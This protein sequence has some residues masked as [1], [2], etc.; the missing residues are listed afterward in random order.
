L[1][2]EIKYKKYKKYR[3]YRQKFR[4][5]NHNGC[6]PCAIG[7]YFLY[8]FPCILLYIFYYIKIAYK[9]Y[10]KYRICFKIC[11]GACFAALYFYVKKCRITLKSTGSAGW[12]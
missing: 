5:S 1:S 7:L 6:C 12:K 8:F 9:K 10:R 11:T 3:K 4:A 2:L